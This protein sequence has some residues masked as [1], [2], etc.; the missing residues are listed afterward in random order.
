MTPEDERAMRSMGVVPI[1]NGDIDQAT[2]EAI[3]EALDQVL[4]TGRPKVRL[5]GEFRVEDFTPDARIY[6][7]KAW[8]VRYEVGAWPPGKPYRMPWRRR[9]RLKADALRERLAVLIAP[10]LDPQ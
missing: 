10:W 6:T 1:K 9:L 5:A 8:G 2:I 4:G 3:E 7:H